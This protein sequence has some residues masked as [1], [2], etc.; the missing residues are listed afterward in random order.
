MQGVKLSRMNRLQR[1]K[2]HLR[3][4]EKNLEVLADHEIAMNLCPA[5]LKTA[6]TVLG[7]MKQ[8]V[9]YKM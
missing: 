4:I 5:L 7:C 1:G 6:N 9:R 8:T 3:A 2:T